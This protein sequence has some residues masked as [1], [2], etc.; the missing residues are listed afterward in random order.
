MAAAIPAV[1]AVGQIG[2]GLYGASNASDNA[3]A[4]ANA[5]REQLAFQNKVLEINQKVSDSQ[6]KDAIARG[7]EEVAANSGRARKI[8]AAQT[9]ALAAQ[10]VDISQGAA[11]DVQRETELLSAMD[12]VKIRNNA[13]REAYGFKVDAYNQALQGQIARVSTANQVRNTLAT[14]GL[15][16]INS[17]VG[18]V[19]SGAQSIYTGYYK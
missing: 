14:G 4:Q 17:G 3:K 5:M 7:E 11:A 1:A 18:G 19:L 15:Q 8:L 16:A 6:F 12:A 9:V 2:L 10:G 13:W